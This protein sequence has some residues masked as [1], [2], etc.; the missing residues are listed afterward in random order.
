[1]T[2]THLIRFE[3]EGKIY[4]GDAIFPD[5]SDPTDVVLI[6]T[7]GQLKARVV[8]NDPFSGD[9]S[10]PEKIVPVEKLLSPLTRA[11]V[12]IIRCIGLNYMKHSTFYAARPV[13]MGFPFN[14]VIYSSGRR[15]YTT[16]ISIFIHQAINVTGS[17]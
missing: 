14:S 11:Q 4:Y 10:Q 7:A 8:A 12:P 15:S 1:M 2:W 9:S 5:G 13:K 3:S 16:S 6:A 17:F